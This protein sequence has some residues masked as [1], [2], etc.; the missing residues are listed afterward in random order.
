VRIIEIDSGGPFLFVRKLRR[1]PP[2]TLLEF[3]YQFAVK[4]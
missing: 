2:N 3:V 1:K 4:K